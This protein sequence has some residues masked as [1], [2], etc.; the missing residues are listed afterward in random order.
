MTCTVCRG[1]KLLTLSNCP[2]VAHQGSG[3]I[4]L[5]YVEGLRSRGWQVDAF[6]PEHF[7]PLRRLRK[8]RSWRMAIGFLLQALRC[9]GRTNYDIVE[10]YGGEAWLAIAV[11]S[12]WPGRRFLLV[13][14]ANGLEPHM[15]RE[16]RRHL[17]ADT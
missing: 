4:T 11:L 7:E 12:R 2:L 16:L 1:M 9:I 3:Y 5:G 14:H 6:G 8:A 17:G 10:V 15:G 13:S